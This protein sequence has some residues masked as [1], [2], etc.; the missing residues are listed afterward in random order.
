MYECV[1]HAEI[2][3]VLECGETLISHTGQDQTVA[4]VVVEL[5]DSC[6]LFL[7]LA[8]FFPP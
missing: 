6:F 1:V 2:V 5:H 3:R 8:N 4:G 7:I